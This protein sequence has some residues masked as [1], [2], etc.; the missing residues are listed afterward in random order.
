MVSEKWQKGL[1]WHRMNEN[2]D[3]FTT[4]IVT[5]FAD[6]RFSFY[7]SALIITILYFPG[8]KISQKNN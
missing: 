7:L 8:R 2:E 3:V 6:S 1:I 5:L 4:Y